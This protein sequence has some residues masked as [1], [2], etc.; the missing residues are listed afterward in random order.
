M[1][2]IQCSTFVSPLSSIFPRYPLLARS[3]LLTAA[4]CSG[5]VPQQ[6]PIMLMPKECIF[7]VAE[8]KSSGDTL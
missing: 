4:M 5:V 1:L 6:P 8:A 2:D 7:S 3:F